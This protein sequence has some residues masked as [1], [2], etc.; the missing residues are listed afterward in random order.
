M[1]AEQESCLEPAGVA[2]ISREDDLPGKVPA[3][4]EHLVVVGL[5]TVVHIYERT[6]D[7][8]IRAEAMERWHR[9][10]VLYRV[11]VARIAMLLQVR[12]PERASVLVHDGEGAVEGRV[13]ERVICVDPC[14]RLRQTPYSERC[15]TRCG[16][17][18]GEDWGLGRRCDSQFR[19]EELENI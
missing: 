5:Q 9:V 12:L 7:L 2:A 17:P 13:H 18:C 6:L 8:A 11:R 1:G 3:R 19:L 4:S 15:C 16:R 10:L 14:V